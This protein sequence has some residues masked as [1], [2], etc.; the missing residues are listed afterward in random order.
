MLTVGGMRIHVVGIGSVG[1]LIATHLR[2]ILPRTHQIALIHKNESRARIMLQNDASL[3]VSSKFGAPMTASGFETDVCKS[4]LPPLNVDEYYQTYRP[5]ETRE[6][7]V[8]M[9]EEENR[10]RN[11]AMER[12]N[13]IESLIVT[14]K[15]HATRDVISNLRSRISPNSTIVLLQNGLGMYEE[16]ISGIFR[17]PKNR[18][19]FILCSNTHG[20]LLRT[21]GEAIH[22]GDGEIQFGIV[23]DGEQNCEASMHDQAIPEDDRH[24]RIDDITTPKAANY[25]RYRSLRQTVAALSTLKALQCQWRPISDIHVALR[26]KAV[27]NAFINP[28]TALMNC[29]NGNLLN[30][31]SASRIRD[32]ICREAEQLFVTQAAQ[33]GTTTNHLDLSSTALS[34]ECRRVLLATSSNIS[35]MLQDVRSG[36]P[37]EIEYINGFL[38]RQGQIYNV[39]MPSTK[40]LYDLVKLRSSIP[41]D[42]LL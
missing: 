15:A 38:W 41:M 42:P 22:T 4:E 7:V 24:L 11:N 29:Q 36:K 28:V 32:S 12:M 33:E 3:R 35:S 16:L 37:T 8:E 23:P 10:M 13:T 1:T 19:H 31:T 25:G 27:V 21:Q 6:H 34:Q 39:P 2:T 9:V 14:V 40:Q 20:S 18:P 26:R 30:H 17:D 5:G